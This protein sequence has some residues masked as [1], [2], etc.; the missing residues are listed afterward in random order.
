MSNIH[1][2]HDHP[3]DPRRI[4]CIYDS[5]KSAGCID[6]MVQIP[7]REATLF[8]LSLVHS[9]QHIQNITRTAGISK[10]ELLEVASSYDSI[11]LN[12]SSSLC[13][14]LSCG[15]LLE[16]CKAVAMGEVSNG[17]AIVRP[18]GHH[19]EPDLAGGFCLYNNV[20]IAARYLQHQFDI[21]KIF[22]LDWDIHH[23]NG[24]QK[25]FFNDPNV[26]YCSI[27]RYD[28]GTFYPGDPIAAAHKAVGSGPGRGKTINI[29][30]PCLGMGDSEYIYAFLK[31]VM[32]I[33]YEFAPDFILVSAGFDAAKGDYIGQNMITPA[34]Y[35]HMTHMLK[36]L[37]GG[38]VVLALEGGYNLDSIAVSALACTKALLSDPIDML[39]PIIPNEECMETIRKVLSVQ[40]RYWKSMTPT[41][42]PMETGLEDVDEDDDDVQVIEMTRILSVYRTEFLYQTHKMAKL[43]LSNPDYEQQ[44]NMYTDK[45]LYI[46]VHD[47]GEL[48]ARTLGAY[49]IIRADKSMLADSV[50]Q[51]VDRIIK[52]GNDLID[53]VVPFEPVTDEEWTTL[54]DNMAG[55]LTD[56]WDN[57]VSMTGP[58][59]RI[60]LLA[61][62]VG[63]HGMVAFM[64]R[65]QQEIIE[66]VSCVV[67]VPDSEYPLPMVTPRLASWY[68]KNSFVVV[69]DDHSIWGRVNQRMNDRIGNLVRSGRPAGCLSEL[70]LYLYYTMFVEIDRKLE[71]LPP[72][73]PP[74][75][76]RKK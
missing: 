35:A 12:H 53:I 67:L 41:H 36:S 60:I 44:P 25:A 20:A 26:V 27:H 75:G 24:T 21:K 48:S 30:W 71:S 13:A 29:P 8:E 65:R 14:R 43:P 74:E 64:N 59:R 55:L 1:G 15:S 23:G 56:I 2:D 37:A 9:L 18:P 11:Y 16:L 69:A 63:C 42:V 49:N 46:F 72:L 6:R 54:R 58:M 40:S 76:L 4:K 31:V 45:P 68:M 33:V 61:T 39:G 47:I 17:V 3:E 66:F 51:Y 5:L 34:G 38:K 70:L 28:D 52:T 7:S 19:A 62:G 50:A 10:E 22:I 73:R 57:F 32:P